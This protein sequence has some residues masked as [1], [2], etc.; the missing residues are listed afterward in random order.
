MLPRHICCWLRC[1]SFGTALQACAHLPRLFLPCPGSETVFLLSSKAGGCGLNLVGANRPLLVDPSWNP[2]DD[3][4]AAG[5]VWRDGQRKR[6]YVY[7]LL[8]A[9]T[10]EEKVFQRQVSK[11]GEWGRGC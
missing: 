11:E 3:K 2:A 10:I 1:L 6:V 5:R 8:S 9:G 7:R 4:Q